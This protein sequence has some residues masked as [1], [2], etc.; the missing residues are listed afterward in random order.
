MF[1]SLGVH[2]ALGWAVLRAPAGWLG[3]PRQVEPL[4]IEIVEITPDPV[5]PPVEEEPP[6]PLPP[7]PTE[8]TNVPPDEVAATLTPRLGIPSPLEP[9]ETTDGNLN[10]NPDTVPSAI[11]VPDITPDEPH[12]RVDTNDRRAM[13]ALL[14]PSS[15]AAGGFTPTGPGPSQ[16][17]AP[18]GLATGTERPSEQDI[19][20]QH[21]EHLRGRAM[22]RP[23]LARTE[24]ELQRQPDG[25]LAYEG[26]RFRAVIRPDGEVVFHDQGNAQTDGF[27]TSGSFDLTDAL[28]GAAG[29]DPHAAERDWFMRRTREVRHRL[30]AAHRSQ[31][32]AQGLGRLRAY[33]AGVWRRTARSTGARRRRIFTVWDEMADDET[34]RQG[35]AFILAFIR[36]NLPA[37]SEDAYTDA[38]LSRLNARRESTQRFDPY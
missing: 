9:T 38:E 19:E 16:R 26:H 30:E 13:Q 33:I 37:G 23:W 35:R 10:P 8:E 1:L 18:A 24:P 21:Q 34:G 5:R 25:S 31:Q 3:D 4:A 27:S 7:A 22:A 20:R 28:M 17:G 11:D 14:N 12:P 32:N 15:V 2:G 29:Q 36:D 6:P